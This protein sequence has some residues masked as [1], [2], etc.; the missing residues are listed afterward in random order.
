MRASWRRARTERL[1]FRVAVSVVGT[2]ASVVLRCVEAC[3]IFVAGS[4]CCFVRRLG[5]VRG[6]ILPLPR[7][8]ARVLAAFATH[9][10]LTL[11]L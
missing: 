1:C 5:L 8:R 10:F 2:R 11:H 7:Q 4:K 9:T 3:R 6:R